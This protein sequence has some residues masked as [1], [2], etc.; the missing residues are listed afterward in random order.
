LPLSSLHL[1]PSKLKVATMDLKPS[2]ELLLLEEKATPTQL[3]LNVHAVNAHAELRRKNIAPTMLLMPLEKLS[4][5]P[6]RTSRE[7]LRREKT[8]RKLKLESRR[9][10][11]KPRKLRKNKNPLMKQRRS[12]MLLRKPSTNK[13]KSTPRKSK[14]KLSRKPEKTPRKRLPKFQTMLIKP[15]KLKLLVMLLIKLPPRSRKEPINLRPMLP[16]LKLPPIRPPPTLKPLEKRLLI[17]LKPPEKRPML[18]PNLLKR[19]L[20]MP[21]RKPKMPRIKHLLN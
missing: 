17:P 16:L 20:T 5:E 11:R 21:R 7:K 4:R 15:I 19:K 18:L 14:T 6:P 13:L 8:K 2:L 9:L 12:N 1:K 3:K 10:K